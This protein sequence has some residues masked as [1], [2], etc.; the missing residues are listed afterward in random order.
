MI[1]LIS[2]SFYCDFG[3]L[4]GSFPIVAEG[5]GLPATVGK[6]LKIKERFRRHVCK[7]YR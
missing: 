1:P 6:A 5:V 2:L 4:T 7:V 3:G